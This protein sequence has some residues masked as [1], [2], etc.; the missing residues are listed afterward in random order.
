MAVAS[1][2][3]EL[4]SVW[5]D[6]ASVAVPLL[7]VLGLAFYAL[8]SHAYEQ[9]YGSLGTT[10]ADVGLTYFGVLAAST[11]WAVVL[12][13]GLAFLVPM[14]V[15]GLPVIRLGGSVGQELKMGQLILMAPFR[16]GW[17][18]LRSSIRDRE[19]RLPKDEQDARW[20][21]R[22]ADLDADLEREKA[23]RD[24]ILHTEIEPGL[25]LGQLWAGAIVIRLILI[26]AV[27]LLL[28]FLIERPLEQINRYTGQVQAG[29]PGRVSAGLL[30]LPLVRLR[31]DEVRVASAGE[32]GQFPAAD[33]LRGRKLIYLGRAD[34]TVV[35]Y[36]SSSR[37][38]YYL[39][40][41]T[42]VL[43]LRGI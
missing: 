41:S 13:L 3:R 18:V 5:R 4:W 31:A 17:P 24:R 38:S 35:L 27:F 15:Y 9:F 34:S 37:M 25:K 32:L 43:E 1:D 26:I 42:V 11:G 14:L 8:S 29:H 6:I 28:S 12:G 22:E 2:E 10:P 20:S 23:W 21:A 33:R 39:P 40:A 30:G 7:T 19:W 16:Y 36:E